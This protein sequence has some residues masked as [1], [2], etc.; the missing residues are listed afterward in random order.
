MGKAVDA[1]LV[2]T[3]KS[4]EH[5]LRT[6]AIY[7]NTLDTPTVG[8]TRHYVRSPAGARPGQYSALTAQSN[9][10]VNAYRTSFIRPALASVR[11]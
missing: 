2:T 5:T 1:R 9:T 7:K 4:L 6:R 3:G 8:P 10:T 11:M